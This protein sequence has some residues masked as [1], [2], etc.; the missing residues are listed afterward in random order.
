MNS[1]CEASKR[2]CGDDAWETCG[3]ANGSASLICGVSW[4]YLELLGEE[5]EGDGDDDERHATDEEAAPPHADPVAVRRVWKNTSLSQIAANHVDWRVRAG[6]Q[7]DAP[8][9]FVASK[10]RQSK[11]TFCGLFGTANAKCCFLRLAEY[12]LTWRGT[13]AH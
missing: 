2:Q 8:R 10:Y 1:A 5:K 3:N 4:H 12:A 13:P 11:W 9:A 6:Q 7:S